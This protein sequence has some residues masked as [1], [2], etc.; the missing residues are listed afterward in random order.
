MKLFGIAL[1]GLLSLG[2]TQIAASAQ[3]PDYEETIVPGYI[4][5]HS[6]MI[7]QVANNLND[8]RDTYYVNFANR[9]WTRSGA[10]GVVSGTW[11]PEQDHIF[12]SAN[13]KG[14]MC[15]AGPWAFAGC[16]VIGPIVWVHCEGSASAAVHRAQRE[17]QRGGRTLEITDS[18][19][20]G[21]RMKSRCIVPSTIV[22]SEP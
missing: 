13:P 12:N 22:F 7:F 6:E 19:R 2:M 20:C 8:E 14:V 18:G 1:M 9:Q 16:L 5:T 3:L 17:C 4:V 11:S 10:S 21:Q 15:L